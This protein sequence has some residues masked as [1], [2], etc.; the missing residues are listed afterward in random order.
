MC[1]D[2]EDFTRTVVMLDDLALYAHTDGADQH[3]IDAI[4]PSLAASLPAPPP[5]TFPPGFDPTD[6]PEYPGEGW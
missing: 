4:G 6:G 3:F 1:P 5:G 2:R